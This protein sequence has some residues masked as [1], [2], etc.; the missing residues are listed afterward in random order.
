M[1]KKIISLLFISLLAGCTPTVTSSEKSSTLPPNTT[2]TSEQPPS[3]EQPTTESG[4]ENTSTSEQTTSEPPTPLNDELIDGYEVHT[5]WPTDLI[6]SYVGINEELPSYESETRYYTTDIEDGLK[7]EL[8]TRVRTLDVIDT[9]LT[10]LS[11]YN[12]SLSVEEDGT[13]FGESMYKN[14]RLYAFTR[15]YSQGFELVL[16]IMEGPGDNYDGLVVEDGLARFNF[17]STRDTPSALTTKNK[18]RSVWT[19]RPVRM[20]ISKNGSQNNVGNIGGQGDE[21]LFNPLRVYERQIVRWQLN[22]IRLHIVKVVIRTTGDE[23]YIETTLN[24]EFNNAT[25]L[26]VER[27]IELTPLNEETREVSLQMKAYEGQTRWLN[28]DVYIA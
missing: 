12:F 10:L 26:R 19:I 11:D 25:A 21:H 1:N 2:T 8:I 20:S 17:D 18:D 15:V 3:S 4:S 27:N 24:A 7:L 5:S 9:Y 16:E 6:V 22:D 28:V 13:H 14:I 23:K